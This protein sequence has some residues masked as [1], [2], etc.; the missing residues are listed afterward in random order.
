MC[1]RY[2]LTT[3][4]EAVRAY[5]DFI[6]LP[7]LPPRAN[8]A[9]RQEVAAVRLGADDGARHFVWLRWG[10]IPSWAKDAAIGDRMINARAESVAEKPAFRDAFRTRRCLIAADGFYEWRNEGGRKQPHRIT[11][12]DADVFAFAGIWEHWRDPHSNEAVETCAILTTEATAALRPIHHRM[13]VILDPANFATWLN[14]GT[15][16]KAVQAL[17][18][19]RRS[20]AFTTYTVSTRINSAANDDLSLLAPTA[21]EIDTAAQPRLL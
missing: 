10:L 8:I 4:V 11:M 12:S 13:P 21:P 15:N 2:S 20:H 19:Q 3:P 18:N 17:L 16:V 1:G 14:P 7:N 6:E 5:F 9:P